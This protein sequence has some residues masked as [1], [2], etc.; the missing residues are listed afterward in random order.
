MASSSITLEDPFVNEVDCLLG[1]YGSG[2]N[3][4]LRRN[5][6][7]DPIQNFV[8]LVELNT[9]ENDIIR[10]ELLQAFEDGF[11][12][13]ESIGFAGNAIIFTPKIL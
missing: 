11:Q 6:T 4:I 3:V 9:E 5:F 1:K 12:F 13:I 10:R 8:Y 7:S 2:V